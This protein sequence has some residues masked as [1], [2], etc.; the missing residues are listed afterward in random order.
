VAT[1][2]VV[3]DE[4]DVRSF[5][6]GTLDGRGYRVLD[7]R[8][9]QHAL[10]IASQ[11]PIHLLLT[12]VVMALIKGTELARR[13]QALSLSTKVLLM[14]A[15]TLSEVAASAYD[16]IAK[17]FTADALTE[18]VRQV[19]RQPSPFARRGPRGVHPMARTGRGSRKIRPCRPAPVSGAGETRSDSHIP[20]TFSG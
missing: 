3:D 12:D 1:I 16:F 13:L 8:D 6:R 5:V 10:R 20:A 18:R 9:P 15:Y 4:E 14:S 2:L 11:Q 7:T 19:L 17:P